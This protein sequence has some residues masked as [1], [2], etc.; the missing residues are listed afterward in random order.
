M[1]NMLK[2]LKD[3]LDS[4]QEQM[5][6]TSSEMKILRK[7]HKRNARDQKHWNRNEECL[8]WAF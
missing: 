7:N 2:A 3:K 6:N 8:R 1:I 4:M 5:D